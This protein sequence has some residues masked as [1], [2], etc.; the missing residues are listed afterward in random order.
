MC[1]PPLDHSGRYFRS[2]SA[3]SLLPQPGCAER[4]TLP[5]GESRRGASVPPA[6]GFACG[7]QWVDLRLARKW[8]QVWHKREDPCGM[9][10]VACD[11]GSLGKGAE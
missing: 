7:V 3:G 9:G 10:Q 11:R 4:A 5:P 2:L 8:L 6:R 1:V